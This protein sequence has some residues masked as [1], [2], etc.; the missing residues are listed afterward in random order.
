MCPEC[1]ETKRKNP[2]TF[3][4]CEYFGFITDS[5]KEEF[6]DKLMKFQ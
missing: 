3:T 1:L 4:H 5:D 2:N 6:G